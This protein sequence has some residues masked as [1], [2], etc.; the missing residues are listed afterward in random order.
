M[1]NDSRLRIGV[2]GARGFIGSHLVARFA[3][4]GHEV[5]SYQRVAS[6]PP[7]PGVIP[8]RF[9]MPGAIEP[10]EFEGL[11]VLIHAALVE[12]GPAHRD[13]DAI[14]QQSL[15][16]LIE[17]TRARNI[18]LVFLSS[19]SAHEEARSHYGRN[20]LALEARLDPARD[21]ILRL[22][23][24]LGNGG[25][26]GSMVELIRG[27]RVIP[28][29]DGGRQPIQTIWMGDLLT[30]VER[31]VSQEIGGRYEVATP[32]VYTMREL[33]QTV[34]REL[35]VSRPL[36]PVPLAL[37]G[38]G[39]ATLEALHVPFSINSENVLGLRY[40]RAFDNAADMRALAVEPI[41]LAESVRRL[42]AKG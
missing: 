34:M 21:T 5:H 28:L 32:E 33:Y 13:A 26:F 14:N 37:V 29:P 12:Y 42:L 39:V 11:D 2:T 30:V 36:V 17:I 25:L 16:R 40:L 8:H 1:T 7:M 4:R 38:L 6:A 15:D 18:R 3:E 10:R 22:G 19:L 20:K 24:V 23:L 27:A 9:E 31:V 35:G 41:G